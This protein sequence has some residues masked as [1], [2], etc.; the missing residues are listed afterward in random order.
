MIYYEHILRSRTILCRIEMI[1]NTLRDE[2]ETSLSAS[3]FIYTYTF[4]RIFLEM[5]KTYK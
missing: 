5:I 2:S 3:L 4:F 1:K